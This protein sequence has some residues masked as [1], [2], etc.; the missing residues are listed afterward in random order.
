MTNEMQIELL[1]RDGC[2]KNEAI[3]FLKNGTTIFED[4]EE[5]IEEYLDEWGIDEDYKIVYR[6][7]ITDGI[8]LPEDWSYV[9]VD[10]KKY[11]IMYVL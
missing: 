7:M 11:Y 2:T 4:F 1:M 3:K 9:K 10:G 5:N 6:S 8:L